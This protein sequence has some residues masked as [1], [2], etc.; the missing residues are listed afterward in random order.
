MIN[1]NYFKFLIKSKKYFTLFVLLVTILSILALGK[2]TSIYFNYGLSILLAYFMPIYIFS[3]VHDKKAI[4]SYYSL[5]ISRKE[6][7]F[8][9]LLYCLLIALFPYVL[10]LI[11][12]C[13]LD[14]DIRVEYFVYMIIVVISIIGLITFN[15]LTYLTGHNKVDG[16]IMC[17]AYNVF[18]LLI[19][20]A[21]DYFTESFVAGA[22]RLYSELAEYLSPIALS[23]VV[24]NRHTV[25]DLYKSGFAFNNKDYYYIGATIVLLLISFIL[26]YF[27][28]MKRKTEKAGSCSDKLYAYPFIIYSYTFLGMFGLCCTYASYSY[29]QV[30]EF[31]LDNFIF[32]LIIF[33]MFVCAHFI[34]KRKFYISIKMPLFFVGVLALTLLFSTSAKLTKGFG[35]SNLYV[36]DDP[37]LQYELTIY[38]NDEV[39]KWASEL[40]GKQETYVSVS[41]TVGHVHSNEPL[42][43]EMIDIFEKYRDNAIEDFYNN[44]DKQWYGYLQVSNNSSVGSEDYRRAYDYTIYEEITADVI[45]KIANYPNARVTID[46]IDATYIV[47]GEGNLTTIEYYKG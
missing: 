28:F 25:S 47:D 30:F 1:L 12:A 34:Y 4:D 5:P 23:V 32:Y 19:A 29:N 10:G 22:N 20:I 8:T 37:N 15:T 11:V 9:S 6:L 13:I 2:T 3:F 39:K 31:I 26:L 16:I 14:L 44:K 35:L 36:K 7:L 21:I 40:T 18:P 17:G 38:D 41:L 24:F 45:M 27:V 46:T 42:N 33:I 43:K